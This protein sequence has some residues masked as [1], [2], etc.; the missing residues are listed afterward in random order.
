MSRPFI[1]PSLSSIRS[2][3]AAWP[4]TRPLVVPW[5]NRMGKRSFRVRVR[6]YDRG[7]R[8]PAEHGRTA[9]EEGRRCSASNRTCSLR[10]SAPGSRDSER[11]PTPNGVS[12]LLGSAP[13]RSR[14]RRVRGGA[15]S[16]VCGSPLLVTTC[17]CARARWRPGAVRTLRS[18][19]PRSGRMRG[20]RSAPVRAQA[21]TAV[22]PASACEAKRIE[23][24]RQAKPQGSRSAG[25]DP[26]H[27][28]RGRAPADPC[29][30]PARASLSRC[31]GTVVPRARTEACTRS[32]RGLRR[33][34]RKLD[35]PD[36]RA[37]ARP[38][39]GRPRL[40]PHLV[41]AGGLWRDRRRR[42]SA[43]PDRVRRT[44]R[45]RLSP[46]RG[47]RCRRRSPRRTCQ[48]IK[49]TAARVRGLAGPA[50]QGHVPATS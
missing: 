42:R 40:V 7:V 46:S 29:H 41:P 22:S 3:A 47:I 11:M 16:R 34:G 27:V 2:R 9:R 12:L 21:R 30:H 15:P 18:R 50:V 44:T 43:A 10:W 20:R 4:S 48:R 5:A 24:P 33:R 1:A 8:A 28:R 6:P 31:D 23:G 38:G 39:T 49:C 17:R 26:T 14:G 32:A 37:R 19:A 45:R 36:A 13:N 35:R 25:H